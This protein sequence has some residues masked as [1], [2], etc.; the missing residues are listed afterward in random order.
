MTGSN[1]YVCGEGGG[2]G[3][4][5]LSMLSNEKLPFILG[6]NVQTVMFKGLPPSLRTS[7]A[8]KTLSQDFKV[9][10]LSIKRLDLDKVTW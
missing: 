2:W 10:S 3:G 8:Q 5:W 9:K 7:A 1:L 4:Q 6:D